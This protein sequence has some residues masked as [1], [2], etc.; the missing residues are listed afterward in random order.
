MA[1]IMAWL[2]GCGEV[3]VS[4]CSQ[5]TAM[6]GNGLRLCQGRFRFGIRTHLSSERAVMQW[7][8][9]PRGVMGSPSLEVVLS[10]ADVALRDVGGWGWTGVGLGELRGLFKP[11]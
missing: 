7:N 8:R 9:L 6:R 3:G 4:L 1:R 5:L 11:E 2:L 10:C